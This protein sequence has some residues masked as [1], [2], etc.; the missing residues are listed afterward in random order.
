[1]LSRANYELWKKLLA[2]GKRVYATA[3]NDEHRLP[4]DKA[5][6]TI[7]A[8]EKNSRAFIQQLRAGNITCGGVGVRMCVGDTAM[9]GVCDFAGQKLVISVGDFHKSLRDPA[10]T[11][12]VALISDTG[13]VCSWETSC[14]ET[15]YFA[16]DADSEKKFYR[17]AVY[18][19]TRDFPIALGN[20]IWNER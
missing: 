10:H 2:L 19:N 5:L 8:E 14:E 1:M 20:P 15:A 17:V 7:Y 3:G 11:Y 9:G 12:R 18:D 16:I 6:T 4:K 13:E